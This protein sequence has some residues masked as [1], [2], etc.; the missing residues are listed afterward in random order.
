MI[1]AGSMTVVIIITVIYSLFQIA[2]YIRKKYIK[3][4]FLFLVLTSVSVLYL[5]AFV[6]DINVP[7]PVDI[8][9]F[10][11]NPVSRLIFDIKRY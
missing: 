5:I 11:F 8:V 2:Y 1:K 4:I 3:E 9:E 7:K 6:K 10:I